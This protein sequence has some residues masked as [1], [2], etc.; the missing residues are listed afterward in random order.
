[1]SRRSHL[2]F[3]LSKRGRGG[4][5]NKGDMK[6]GT[7]VLGYVLVGSRVSEALERGQIKGSASLIRVGNFSVIFTSRL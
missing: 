6:M 1:M 7:N 3:F 4:T 2:D 5:Q